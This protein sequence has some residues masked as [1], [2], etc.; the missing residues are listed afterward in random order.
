[1]PEAPHWIPIPKI[2]VGY[3]PVDFM[4]GHALF[5]WDSDDVNFGTDSTAPSFDVDL[6][7][8]QLSV[9]EQKSAFD[10]WS[11]SSDSFLLR[12]PMQATR[13]TITPIVL[14]FLQPLRFAN[15]ETLRPVVN[16]GV[17]FLRQT[18]EGGGETQSE[19]LPMLR[20]GIGAE[21]EPV[22][23]VF[24]RINYEYSRIPVESALNPDLPERDHAIQTG[25]EIKF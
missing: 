9:A 14:S 12:D 19:M 16:V 6:I 23:Q 1:V 11:L 5:E 10:N 4:F 13:T 8:A 20:A 15:W 3:V 25:V 24:F 22:K 21:W 2:K 17:G 18:V 7:F